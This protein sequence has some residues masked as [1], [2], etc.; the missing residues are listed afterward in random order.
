M[1]D[2]MQVEWAGFGQ[3]DVNLVG[4]TSPVHESAPGYIRKSLFLPGRGNRLF[5]RTW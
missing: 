3:D 4:T 1:K 2:S 5:T